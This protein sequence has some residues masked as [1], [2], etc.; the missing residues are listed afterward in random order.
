VCVCVCVCRIDIWS[1]EIAGQS[2]FILAWE[3]PRATENTLGKL[4]GQVVSL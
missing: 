1:V 4:Q 2:F 3:N